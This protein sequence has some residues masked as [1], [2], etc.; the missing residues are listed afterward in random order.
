MSP[1]PRRPYPRS[2]AFRNTECDANQAS[3]VTRD[4]TGPRQSQG[5]HDMHTDI[6][7]QEFLQQWERETEGTIALL[8][9]L[10]VDRYD[11]RPDAGGRSIGELAWHLAEVD[12]YASVGILQ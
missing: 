11:F 10:P 12:A 5:H 1:I 9:A 2:S 6:E 7:L 4:H 3:R 8:R